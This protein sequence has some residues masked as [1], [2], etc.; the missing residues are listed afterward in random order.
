MGS[1]EAKHYSRTSLTLR[2][3]TESNLGDIRSQLP[4]FFHKLP[5]D[6]VQ[7]GLVQVQILKD[8]LARDTNNQKLVV[9]SQQ[10]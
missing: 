5:A 3:K 4:P 6:S 1:G 9:N 8:L 10:P 2:H 7:I